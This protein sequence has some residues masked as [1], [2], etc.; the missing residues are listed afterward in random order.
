MDVPSGTIIIWA[1][2][3]TIP[4]GWSQLSSGF[5][6][7]LLMA[8]T[9]ASIVQN[10]PTLVGGAGHAH[11]GPSSSSNDNFTHQHTTAVSS[12]GGS[13]GN[14]YNGTE[15]G[16]DIIGANH[17]HTVTTTFGN[18]S[19]AHTHSFTSVAVGTASATD[20]MPPYRTDIL[21]YKI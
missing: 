19:V 11:S 5:N 1:G 3:G 10:S 20:I 2:A 7:G 12:V 14:I 8:Y 18:D 17:N 13:G 21:I 16:Y 9:D 6:G 15:T 4:D